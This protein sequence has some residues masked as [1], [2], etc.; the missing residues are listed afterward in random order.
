VITARR[1]GSTRSSEE[2]RRSAPALEARSAAR[3]VCRVSPRSK[4]VPKLAGG[5]RSPQAMRRN[6]PAWEPA[7]S[8]PAF[9][10]FC[11]KA[12]SP[13]SPDRWGR[14]VAWITDW[15]T[16]LAAAVPNVS[17]R[18][19]SE[20]L[21]RERGAPPGIPPRRPKRRQTPAARAGTLGQVFPAVRR[22][23]GTERWLGVES[24]GAG[25]FRAGTAIPHV[26]RPSRPS[27]RTVT[28]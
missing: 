15:V 10:A 28:P 14:N 27:R 11:S 26:T 6:V 13:R 19:P 20:W 7:G 12:T 3:A 9:A 24:R 1:S 5:R 8:H 16:H 23:R 17:G 21:K 2:T 18:P 25:G 4:P 22:F